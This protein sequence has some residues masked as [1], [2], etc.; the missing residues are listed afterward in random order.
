MHSTHAGIVRDRQSEQ[1]RLTFCVCKKRQ[2]IHWWTLLRPV[3]RLQLI[4]VWLINP[5]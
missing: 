4:S 1:F 2:I 5:V 3:S